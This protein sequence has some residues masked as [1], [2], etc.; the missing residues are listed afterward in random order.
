MHHSPILAVLECHGMACGTELEIK[1]GPATDKLCIF[2][3]MFHGLQ[4]NED[5]ITIT[6]F[7]WH[8][9]SQIWTTGNNSH[10]PS[11]NLRSLKMVSHITTATRTY[12]CTVVKNSLL[13]WNYSPQLSTI[14]ISKSSRCW[15]TPSRACVAWKM[16]PTWNST[17]NSV[18][19]NNASPD[20]TT[21]RYCH[22]E[23]IL[24]RNLILNFMS[25]I[26]VHRA[27]TKWFWLK[28]SEFWLY[29]DQVLNKFLT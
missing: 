3:D 11:P 10:T 26:A 1:R 14:V 2:T 21:I 15:C 8:C 12:I 28:K 7:C 25:T 23:D 20:S 24:T 13:M 18:I 29:S 16:W 19:F 4:A 9:K 27:R 5:D 6:R 17:H 22:G